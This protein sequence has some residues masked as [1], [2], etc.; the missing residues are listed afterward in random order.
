M[1]ATI[2][3][4]Y[5]PKTDIPFATIGAGNLGM[6]KLDPALTDKELDGSKDIF[7]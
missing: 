7:Y 5:D 6:V 1:A 4:A 3:T 2:E